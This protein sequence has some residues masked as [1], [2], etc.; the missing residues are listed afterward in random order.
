MPSLRV[1]TYNING[2]TA[3]R[4]LRAVVRS[5]S[6]DILVCNEAPQMPVLWRLACASLARE[7]QL[8]YV[9]GG[10]N[11]GRNVIF[12]GSYVGVSRVRVR[13]IPQGPFQPIRG[14][15]SAQLHY[16]NRAFGVVGFH[17]GLTAAGRA[18]DLDAVLEAV[19]SLEGPV[20]VAGDVNEEPGEACWRRLEAEGFID[21]ARARDVTF[22]SVTPIRR[23]DALL[24]RG[25]GVEVTDHIVPP[26]AHELVSRASDHLPVAATLH[27]IPLPR[28]ARREGGAAESDRRPGPAGRL[29]A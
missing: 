23:I 12:A 25:D 19:D 26:V 22:P 4:E 11:G 21:H 1:M 7:W 24:V 14:V 13:R 18:N 15:V 27:W 8:E 9:G 16:G 3:R 29:P 17:L 20:I 28:H 10:R 6:P 5:V 2:A